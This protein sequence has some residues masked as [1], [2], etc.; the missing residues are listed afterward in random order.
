[1]YVGAVRN[2]YCTLV[3]PYI[4]FSLVLHVFQELDQVATAPESLRIW[5]PVKTN[6]PLKAERKNLA[7]PCRLK[8]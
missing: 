3:D 6:G 7:G 8:A 2:L 4:G 1:M 5:A